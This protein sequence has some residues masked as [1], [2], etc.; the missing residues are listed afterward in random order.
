MSIQ[1]KTLRQG[2]KKV[3]YYYPVIS[4]YKYTKS[5][6][7]LWGPGF[8]KK[9]D[10]KH[11]EAKMLRD[12]E[13]TLSANK[14]KNKKL[15]FRDV[16]KH[17]LET[18]N[19]KESTTYER[20]VDYCNLYLSIFNDIL[21]TEITGIHVQNL[22][23]LL[24]K[25][26]KPKTVNMAFNLLSQIIDYA[27]SPLK[28]IDSNP[29]KENIQRPKIRKKGME[30][31]KF[32]TEEELKYFL[33]HPYTQNDTL[34]YNMYVIH[35]ILGMRPGELCGI[36]IYDLILPLNL[37]SLNYGLDKKNRLTDLKNTGAQRTLKFPHHL[38]QHLKGQ[39]QLSN[40]IRDKSLDYPF[41]F[42]LDNGSSINP[43]TYCQHFQR[44]I[45]RINKDSADMQIKPITPYG[46][47]HTFATLSLMKGVHIKAVAEVMGDSVE[48]VMQNYAHILE[49]MAGDSLEM[50]ANSLFSLK[51]ENK[52]GT[53]GYM[54]FSKLW[55]LLNEKKL[56]SEWLEENGLDHCIVEQLK[57]N[58][59]VTCETLCLICNLFDCQPDKIMEYVPSTQKH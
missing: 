31:D 28:A 47:R 21:I 32:W 22:I 5:K 29:C 20:D 34:Y 16:R 57:N 1:E 3:T 15:K 58:N 43:D 23:T 33:N 30:S 39:I 56:K 12:L 50:M 24:S 59:S 35:S 54:Q 38:I 17:W 2:G 4:T 9:S 11:E 48:T 42:V 45:E 41:L 51:E 19:T 27:V 13:K 46:L 10:A 36:S 6:T 7:P 40:Q 37:L 55:D 44:L 53:N 14:A 25:K 18:R 52:Y 26:Y 8:L 49:N